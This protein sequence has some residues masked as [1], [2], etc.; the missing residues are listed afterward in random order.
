MTDEPTQCPETGVLYPDVECI[1][2][3]CTEYPGH[4]GQH[5][6]PMMGSWGED[7]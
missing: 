4:P 2:V 1:D 5:F 7:W 3:I 6:D